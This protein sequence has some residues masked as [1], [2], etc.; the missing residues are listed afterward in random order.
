[1]FT[2]SQYKHTNENIGLFLVC[3]M[4]VLHVNVKTL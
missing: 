1:M 3:D 4:N 2:G